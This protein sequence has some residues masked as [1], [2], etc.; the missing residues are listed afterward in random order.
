MRTN[1]QMEYQN[2]TMFRGDTLSFDIEV[3]D[4]NENPIT[5]DS[6]FMTCKE[7]PSQSE[8]VFQKSLGV[9]IDQQDGN[10]IVRV[11]P[12]DTAEVTPG[13]YFYDFQ[14]GVGDDVFTILRGVLSIEQ[15]VTS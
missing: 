3:I 4:Q 15:N 2:I 9:G 12:E 13:E 5:V 7:R 1:F 8:K 10:I 6:A 14:I 11:A